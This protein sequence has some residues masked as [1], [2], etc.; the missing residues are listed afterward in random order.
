M[1]IKDHIKDMD[2]L[3]IDLFGCPFCKN[4]YPGDIIKDGIII[5]YDSKES[6]NHKKKCKINLVY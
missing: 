2:N 4:P 3:A 6:R 1:K 5:I